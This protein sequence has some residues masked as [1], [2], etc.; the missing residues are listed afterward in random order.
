MLLVDNS[1]TTETQRVIVRK[2]V[3]LESL[4]RITFPGLILAFC[5]A[6]LSQAKATDEIW[7]CLLYASHERTS[8][9]VPAWLKNYNERLVRL[10]GY[11][12]VR[13]LGQSEVP[14]LPDRP[15]VIYLR[16]NMRV[17][18]NSCVREGSGHYLISLK[19]YHGEHAIVETQARIAGGSP[20]FFRGPAWRDGRLIVAVVIGEWR[21][22][23][24]W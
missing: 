21:W 1:L 2:K 3:C 23:G 14:V 9:D 4:S 18:L 16:G 6:G 7:G 17:Q 5:F 13:S 20:L 8:P 19:L 24:W 12:G 10:A 22:W 11:R 15:A